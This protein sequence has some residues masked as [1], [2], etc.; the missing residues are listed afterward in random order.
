VGL[1]FVNT[2]SALIP[3][4]KA[5]SLNSLFWQSGYSCA[6]STLSIN[7]NH[8]YGAVYRYHENLETPQLIT[9][10]KLNEWK[11]KYP[12]F[13]HII[14]YKNLRIKNAFMKLNPHFNLHLNLPIEGLFIKEII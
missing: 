4:L 10:E 13:K 8:F 14:D 9:Y 6:I 12:N 1:A 3:K 2:L 11:Q 7:K 5:Y